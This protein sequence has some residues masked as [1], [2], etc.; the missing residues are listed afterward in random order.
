[1]YVLATS[2]GVA[3]T[4][5]LVIGVLKPRLSAAVLSCLGSGVGTFAIVWLSSTN[6]SCDTRW[7]LS[8]GVSAGVAVVVL[9]LVAAIGASAGIFGAKGRYGTSHASRTPRLSL[10]VGSAASLQAIHP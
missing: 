1:M 9:C 2:G 7:W 5:L 4:V 10:L 3:G 6:S 8:L